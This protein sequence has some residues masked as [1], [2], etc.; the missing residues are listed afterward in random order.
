M[1][2]TSP[3]AEFRAPVATRHTAYGARHCYKLE[4]QHAG[5]PLAVAVMCHVGVHSDGAVLWCRK[6]TETYVMNFA[7][8]GRLKY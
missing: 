7:Y 3:D 8:W 1:H 2:D 4:K 5:L 6:E